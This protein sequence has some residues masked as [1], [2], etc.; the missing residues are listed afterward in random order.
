[1]AEPPNLMDSIEQ[2][3]QEERAATLG[4]AGKEMEVALHELD[5]GVAGLSEHE[6]LDAAGTKVWYYLIT[7]ESC[8]MYDHKEALAI[9]GVPNHVLA[10]VGVIRR[11]A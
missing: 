6:L 3:L 1:M 7:R 5:T 10:R 4:K 11:R 8:G 2:Q 9:Y